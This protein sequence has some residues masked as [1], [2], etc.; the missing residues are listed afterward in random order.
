ME[1]GY[2]LASVLL[3]VYGQLVV[4]W[5]VLNAGAFPSEPAD[6]LRFL[7]GLL[8]NPWVIS[9]FVATLLAALSWMVAMTRFELSYAYPF[10]SLAYVLV[11]LFSVTLFGE[12]LMVAKVLGLGLII[13]G[14]YV[15]S[16]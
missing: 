14:L 8:L 16:R 11:T 7:A 10:A 15:G 4:K 13:L 3:T 6:R 9:C 1:H 5:Q 12:R 2:I